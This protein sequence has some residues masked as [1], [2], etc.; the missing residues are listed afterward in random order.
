[1]RV[2]RS[3]PLDRMTIRFSLCSFFTGRREGAKDREECRML[4]GISNNE[5]GSLKADVNT[6]AKKLW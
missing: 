4:N 3:Y 2:L 5:Q 6:R 1:M